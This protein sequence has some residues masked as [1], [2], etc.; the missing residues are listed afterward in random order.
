MLALICGTGA[1]PAAVAAAQDIRPL[2]CVLEDFAPDDLEADATFRIE[3]LGSFLLDLGTRGITDICL[4]GAITRPAL[5]PAFLDNETKPLV[6][7]LMTAMAQGDDGALRAVIQLFEQTGFTIRSAEELA[8]DILPGQGVLSTV[9][10]TGQTR[11]DVE[12]ALEAMAEMG[13]RDIGQSCIVR[14]GEVVALEGQDGTD[15]MLSAQAGCYEPPWY[16]RDP[17]EWLAGLR[18]D[19]LQSAANWFSRNDAPV[20]KT[21]KREGGILFKAPKPNQ[22]RR[23]D[24]PTIGPK[25]AMAAAEAGLD[26]IVIEAGG[27]IVLDREQVLRVLDGLGMFLW[28]RAR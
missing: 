8:P 15:A 19:A 7:V 23:A 6:P 11:A 16:G 21:A 13:Q 12:H 3:R 9:H 22:D 20:E 2:I 1:L 17:T 10:P 5:N 27:V 14:Q 4:C 24:L 18:S 25:T 26:G 28:V